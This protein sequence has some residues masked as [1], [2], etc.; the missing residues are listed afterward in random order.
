MPAVISSLTSDRG[1]DHQILAARRFGWGRRYS[2]DGSPVEAVASL[3]NLF[4]T[5][6]APTYVPA[7]RRHAAGVD[8]VV[9]HAPLPLNDAAVL[10]GLPASVPLIIYWH[11]DVLGYPLLRRIISPLT[12]Q[13]L[14][15]ADIIVVSG[16][17]MIDGSDLLT[18]HRQKCEILPYGIN[19]DFWEQLDSAGVERARELRSSA[20]RH[21][22]AVGRLV[23]Y[24]GFAVLIRAMAQIDG[25]ATIVGDGPL[26]TELKSLAQQL[27]VASRVRFTGR[28]ERSEIRALMHSADVLAFPSVTA[29]EAFG[30]SQIEAMAAGL[31]IVNTYLPTTVPMVARHE[32]EGITVPPN[33]PAAL[34]AALERILDDPGLAQ[35]FGASAQARAKSEFDEN[36][37]QRRMGAVYDRALRERGKKLQKRREISR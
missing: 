7:F 23:G 10:L 12:R 36:V 6:V 35:K 24:K 17:A 1:F 37:F 32:Q 9:H 15:R 26:L 19:L 21:V 16:G 20:P 4:S 27:G 30:I 29:A 22:L 14:A 33:N 2:V 25:N 34:A 5:P 13:T 28:I 18:P 8:I 11:A 3:G 31:P